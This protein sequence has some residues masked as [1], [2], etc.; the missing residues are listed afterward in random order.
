ML[1]M[2]CVLLLSERWG[3]AA[4]LLVLALGVREDCGV[5]LCMQCLALAFVPRD[6][7]ANRRAALRHAAAFA[8]I[9]LAWVV[10][11][12]RGV[13][14]WVFGVHENHLRRGWAQWGH[15]WPEVVWHLATSPAQLAHALARSG[16]ASLNL[17]FG[18]A[19]WLVHP[20]F[21]LAV[22]VPGVL[23][24]SAEPIDKRLLWFYNSSFL[25]PGFLLGLY[26]AVD[27]GALLACRLAARR[28]RWAL[29]PAQQ[30][31]AVAA[32]GALLLAVPLHKLDDTVEWHDTYSR[33]FGARVLA[34][35]LDIAHWLRRCPP[36]TAVATD[37]RR[38]VLLPNR[39]TRYLLRHADDADVV[40]IF[41]QVDPFLSGRESADAVWHLLDG[42]PA[43][44]LRRATDRF[45]IYSRPGLSCVDPGDPPI[46]AIPPKPPIPAN[47]A[48]QPRHPAAAQG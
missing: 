30:L 2:F 1:G 28:P 45:R 23:L 40:L 12:A 43:F 7:F 6:L 26:L 38:I 44:V 24:W 4:V 46:P 48:A 20:L 21:G 8:A 9:S 5:Y 35:E 34:D 3:L 25:L 18:L 31:A 11:V 37:Y 36:R 27:R 29:S 32:A 22:N 41:R 47:T 33:H 16:A 15:S 42:D 17:W 13:N 39:T 14:P 10:V 19:P